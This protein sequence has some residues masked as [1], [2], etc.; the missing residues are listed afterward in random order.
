MK[1]KL[2]LVLA[3]VFQFSLVAANGQPTLK[4]REKYDQG[5]KKFQEG[6]YYAALGLF[7]AA[8]AMRSRPDRSPRFT[9]YYYIGLCYDRLGDSEKALAYYR[10][11]ESLG[12]IQSFSSDYQEM[13]DRQVEIKGSENFS[14]VVRDESK[15]KKQPKEGTPATPEVKKKPEAS[16]KSAPESPKASDKSSGESSTRATDRP[17]KPAVTVP[18]REEKPLN[19]KKPAI[20]EKET[21]RN[22]TGKASRDRVSAPAEVKSEPGS[23]GDVASRVSSQELVQRQNL[24][25]ALLSYFDGDYKSALQM[26]RQYLD[27]G[28]EKRQ[29]ASFIAGAALYSRFLL[30]GRQEPDLKKEALQYFAGCGNYKPPQR[31]ISPTILDAYLARR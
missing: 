10:R 17:A 29:I 20:A 19:E 28:G 9:P 3:L 1:R 8:A 24:R 16:Q 22:R 6:N 25:S 12:S 7:E 4:W 21:S 23:P 14:V 30:G 13:L 27:G 15:E 11:S 31:L 26:A 5:L 2:L 18:S